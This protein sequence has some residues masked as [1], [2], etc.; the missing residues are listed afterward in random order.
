M[1]VAVGSMFRDSSRYLDRAL[2]QYEKLQAL[3]EERGD[4]CR[5]VFVENDSTDDTYERLSAFADVARVSDGCPYYESVDRKDRWRHLAW[6]AN[7]TIEQLTDE[8]DVFLYVESDLAWDAHD[9]LR[10]VDHLSLVDVVS[11][12]NVRRDGSYYDIW[13]SRGADGRRFT[14]Q[15]PYHLDLVEP[16]G[17]VEV[18]SMA[19]CT[20]MVADVARLCRF[21]PDDC[22]VGFNRAMRLAG[23]KVWCDPTVRVTHG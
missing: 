18:Q 15:P 8:D 17:L 20:A 19:G 14:A 6:V 11:A 3:V 23:F 1:K 4:E 13:G 12:L 2:A 9:L 16:P 5:F 10:L 21:S 7:H 22:Y